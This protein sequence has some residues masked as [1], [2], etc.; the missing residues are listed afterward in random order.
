[1]A[2]AVAA[3]F[4]LLGMRCAS[5][6]GISAG[7]GGPAASTAYA[8]SSS[9]S[10]PPLIIPRPKKLSIPSQGSAPFPV[11]SE[12]RIIVAD[13]ATPEEL[14]AA[15][16][17]RRE[18]Q[19][20][21]GLALRQIPVSAAA[22]PMG[23]IVIGG[24][25]KNPFLAQLQKEG[26][27]PGVPN[28]PEGYAVGITS[29][30][31][32]IAGK[33]ARGALWG[34]QTAAQLLV[35]SEPNSGPV[36]RA[37][38]IEDW[39]S[40]R[41][42]AV[43]LFY[44]KK[45]LPFQEKL[46]D[47]ILARYKMNGLFIEAERVHWDHDPKAAP[48]WGGT[49]EDL[50]QE[51]AYARERGITVYPLM[52]SFGHMEWLL[53]NG[54]ADLAEDPQT[55]YALN[56][57][58]PKAVAY[59]EGFNAEADNLFGAPGLHVGFDEVTLRGRIPYRSQSPSYAKLFVSAALYW[60]RFLDQRHQRM[61]MW[62]DQALFADD[63]S[64]CFGTAP[65][66]QIAAAIRAGLPKDIVMV[67]WQYMPRPVYPSLNRLRD[68]GF[69]DIVGAT[70]WYPEGIQNFTR[71]ASAIHALGMIQT[72]WCGYESKEDVLSTDERK[73]FTAMILAADYFWNGGEGPSP[74]QLPYDPATVFNR[75]WEDSPAVASAHS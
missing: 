28:K 58:N 62:A 16:A 63:V 67:D 73:Q 24:P 17:L 55:P 38:L 30:C 52:Q 3:T 18:I 12:T 29:N 1:M 35:A 25:A 49:K 74:N 75:Q 61:W 56:Y 20:R 53:Q 10:E 70:W 57:A 19:E 2:A 65:S 26:I 11:T 66:P 33:D 22:T 54:H 31:V 36:L 7:S 41:L 59:Q 72:T 27:L 5:P 60:H 46:I 51:I 9:L 34:A 42:R 4:P 48:D 21:F 8:A 23:A 50:R 40:L 6:L 64:P 71:A 39:P 47:R 32:G 68:A 43:H 37:A 44:G 15:E 45:A 69:K 13:N 14:R